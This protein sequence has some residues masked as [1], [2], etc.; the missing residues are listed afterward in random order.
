VYNNTIRDQ[1]NMY[2]RDESKEEEEITEL[3]LAMVRVEKV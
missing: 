1:N 3:R 2:T